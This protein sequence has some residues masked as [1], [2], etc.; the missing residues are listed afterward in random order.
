MS[1][2]CYKSELRMIISETTVTF[3]YYAW[4]FVIII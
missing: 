3:S 4:N 2:K 1:P